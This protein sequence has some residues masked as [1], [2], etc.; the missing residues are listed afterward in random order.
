M[1]ERRFQSNQQLR[2][3]SSGKGNSVSGYASVFNQT[4]N[5][6]P[7][8]ERIAQGCFLRSLK[9]NPDIRCLVDHDTSK[10]LGRTKSGTLSLSEDAHG[11]AFRVVLPPTSAGTDLGISLAR[12]DV[13]Q[14]SFGFFARDESWNDEVVDG[15]L[16]LVREIREV[17]L[18]EISICAF[19]AYPTTS[20]SLDSRSLWPQGVPAEVRARL[21]TG[22]R[23]ARAEDPCE[24]G[25]DQCIEGDCQECS[26]PDCTDEN[27]RCSDE[28]AAKRKRRVALAL[29]DF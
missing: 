14:A 9:E 5:L 18:I 11:L 20:V 28:R 3:D 24:C 7:F 1:L 4:T 27:C 10:V 21:G 25:C 22:S 8:Y 13:D 26:D 17:S 23:A 2:T 29:E 15:E 12:A 6:G 16:Q 19:G